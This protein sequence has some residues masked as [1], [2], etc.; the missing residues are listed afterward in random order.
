MGVGVFCYILKEIGLDLHAASRDTHGILKEK[1]T[2]GWEA[3]RQRFH[4]RTA[5]EKP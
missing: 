1:T 5:E 2:R 4:L 3:P